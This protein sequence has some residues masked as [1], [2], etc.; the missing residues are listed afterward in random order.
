MPCLDVFRHFKTSENFTPKSTY[1]LYCDPIKLPLCTTEHFTHRQCISHRLCIDFVLKRHPLPM[2]QQLQLQ[3]IASI[4]PLLWLAYLLTFV[5][6][7]PASSSASLSSSSN[8]GPRFLDKFSE[9]TVD[10]GVGVSLKC[11]ASGH[12]LPQMTWQVNGRSVPDDLRFRTGDYVTRCLLVVS[13]VNVSTV[14]PQDG[15]LFVSVFASSS[16]ALVSGVSSPETRR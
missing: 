12:P 3:A 2:Q 16:A 5:T 9:Q 14:Q 4:C 8:S 13:Y 7:V 1:D 11:I 15:G 6:Q 10:P